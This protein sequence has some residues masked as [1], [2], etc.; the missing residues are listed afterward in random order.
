MKSVARI[1]LVNTDNPSAWVTAN[2]KVR[3]IVMTPKCLSTR[4]VYK[5]Q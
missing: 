2:Y 1:R 3:R 5:T 4:V